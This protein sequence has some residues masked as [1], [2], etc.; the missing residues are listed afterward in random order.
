MKNREA[1]IIESDLPML[2]Y[3]G[4]YQK[5]NNWFYEFKVRLHAHDYT[6]QGICEFEMFYYKTII[7]EKLINNQHIRQAYKNNAE[8]LFILESASQKLSQLLVLIK[9]V[10]N[11][12]NILAKEIITTEKKY[13]FETNNNFFFLITQIESILY[14]NSSILDLLSKFY[15]ISINLKFPNSK[16]PTKYG[17]QKAWNK[18]KCNFNVPFDIEL[19]NRQKENKIINLCHDYRNSFTHETCLTLLPIEN[20]NSAEFFISKGN[21]H[22]LNLTLIIEQ[23]PSEIN[24]YLEFYNQNIISTFSNTM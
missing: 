11:Q 2:K 9:H 16:V 15:A 18:L 6:R 24:S 12:L 19:Q 17:Q 13:H 7:F 4:K 14:L 3:L 23:L 22:G 20:N 21:S 10:E 8:P 5:V 1:K